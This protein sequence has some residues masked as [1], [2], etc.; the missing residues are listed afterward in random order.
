VTRAR[1]D[2]PRNESGPRASSR[3][4]PRRDTRD[5]LTVPFQVL[6]TLNE[7]T[8]LDR[9]F[10]PTQLAP[11]SPPPDTISPVEA[12][13]FP[14]SPARTIP[15][16]R[17]GRNPERVQEPGAKTSADEPQRSPLLR[18]GS[19]PEASGVVQRTRTAHRVS[20]FVLAGAVAF[21]AAFTLSRS[22]LD[23]IPLRAVE[24][25]PVSFS[26]EASEPTP[27]VSLKAS[28]PPND[29]RPSEDASLAGDVPVVSFG[30][31]PLSKQRDAKS[32]RRHSIVTRRKPTR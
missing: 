4:F 23:P 19:F 30:D 20:L 8:A 6:E 10:E 32:K 28:A 3:P 12:A 15:T 16:V 7:R 29:A 25:N 26:N 27:A 14:G 24:R 5:E 17:P 21:A 9:P 13:A 2:P 11:P 31:L 22:S 1:S 18:T